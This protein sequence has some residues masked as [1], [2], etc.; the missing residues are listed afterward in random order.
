M[1]RMNYYDRRFTM[2][3]ALLLL[4][5]PVVRADKVCVTSCTAAANSRAPRAT[6]QRTRTLSRRRRC[7][8]RRRSQRIRRRM[9]QCG[10]HT[11]RSHKYKEFMCFGAGAGRELHSCMRYLLLETKQFTVRKPRIPARIDFYSYDIDREH[12]QRMEGIPSTTDI[13]KE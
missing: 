9:A 12:G 6:S 4:V 10:A 11:R 8:A 13:G 7:R 5:L 2:K 1:S 3:I